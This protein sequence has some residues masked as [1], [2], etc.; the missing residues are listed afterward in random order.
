M[1]L[2]ICSLLGE[3]GAGVFLVGAVICGGMLEPKS[4]ELNRL[5]MMSDK[6]FLSS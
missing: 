5:V 3:G 6:R 1:E 2:F 4:G